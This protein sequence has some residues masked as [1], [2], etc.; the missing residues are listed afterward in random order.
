V[1]ATG[2]DVRDRLAAL[3]RLESRQPPIVSVYLDTAWRDEHQRDRTRVFLAGEL[4]AARARGGADPTD[5]AWVEERGAA[6]VD[7]REVPDADGVALFAC[8]AVGL[9]EVLPVRVQLEPRF[10]VAPRAYVR[11]LAALVDGFPPSLVV[12]VDG[13]RARFV[14]V[15]PDGRGEELVLESEVPGHHRRGGWAQLAMSRWA[16][17]IEWH[18]DEHLAA[19][20]RTLVDL[21][22][23][24]AITWIVLAGQPEVLA[25]LRSLLPVR[26]AGR[27]AGTIRGAR[28]EAADA[29]LERAVARLAARE[30]RDAALEAEAVLVEAAKSGRAVAGLAAT[31]EAVRRRA[32]HRLYLLAGFSAPG[33]ACERCD[34]LQE[35]TGPCRLCG[36][37]TDGVELGEAMAERVLAS[38]GWIRRIPAHDG[39]AAVGGVAARL[40]YPV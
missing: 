36:G 34:A 23:A 10:V 14:P 31:L 9:R 29:L 38:G 30:A 18:R 21:V 15:H 11:P 2:G 7:Q 25:R 20:A 28:W 5:L 27:V 24:Q 26:V 19:V 13:K 22:E 37:P 32:V 3:V 4:R 33:A 17:H 39:L 6:L 16:R 12:F 1:T 8:Q 40:R 35:V